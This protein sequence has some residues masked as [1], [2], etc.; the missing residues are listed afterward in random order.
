MLV[1]RH[2]EIKVASAGFKQN[3]GTANTKTG[4]LSV[5]KSGS[6]YR[7]SLCLVVI[8]FQFVLGHPGLHVRD[9]CLYG[10]DSGV[11]LIRRANGSSCV[12]STKDWLEKARVSIKEE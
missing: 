7:E 10:Q 4:G 9:A 6:V 2:H 11:Y 12:T 1:E 5:R 3:A 8:R